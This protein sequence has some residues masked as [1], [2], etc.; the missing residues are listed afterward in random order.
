MSSNNNSRNI[1]TISDLKREERKVRSRIKNHELEIAEKFKQ[2]PEEIVTG[3]VMKI[4]ATVSSS[5]IIGNSLN[6]IHKI[7]D[8]IFS[9][10]E[11]SGSVKGAVIEGIFSII[12]S[13]IKK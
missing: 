9:K 1:S 5:N 8:K 13:F 2:L 12:K 6:F 7:S 4:V 10:N 3:A 11:E